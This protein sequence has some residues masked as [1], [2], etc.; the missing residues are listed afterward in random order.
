MSRLVFL[1]N[2][3][4]NYTEHIVFF[5]YILGQTSIFMAFLV[6]PSAFVGFDYGIVSLIL[7][8]IQIIYSAYCLKRIYR[9]NLIGIV[10]KTLLFLLLLFVLL[11]LFSIVMAFILIKSGTFQEMME[12]Q[13]KAEDLTYIASSAMNWTS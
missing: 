6:L 10:F 11:I 8:P 1:K 13:K 9:L 4:Y 3:K 7:I 12:A 5:M 2:K